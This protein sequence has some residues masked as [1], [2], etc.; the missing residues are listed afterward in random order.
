MEHLPN[1]MV[2]VQLIEV[3]TDF[4]LTSNDHVEGACGTSG[5]EEMIVQDSMPDPPTFEQK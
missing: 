4:L 5:T 3:Q 2:S 1:Q